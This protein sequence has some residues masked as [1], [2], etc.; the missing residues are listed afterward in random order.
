M[1]MNSLSKSCI[2]NKKCTKLLVPC[3]GDKM[4]SR[5]ITSWNSQYID[6]WI[7]FL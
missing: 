6:T 4:V 3:T 2:F 1:S 7:P 5:K